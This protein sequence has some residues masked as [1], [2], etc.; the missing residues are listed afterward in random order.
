MRAGMRAGVPCPYTA[1]LQCA[2]Q[3]VALLLYFG[4]IVRV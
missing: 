1:A 2:Q 4:P 3:A